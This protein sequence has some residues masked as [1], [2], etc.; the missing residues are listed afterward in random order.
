VSFHLPFLSGSSRVSRVTHARC[1][2]SHATPS[3]HVV[4]GFPEAFVEVRQRLAVEFGQ[5]LRRYTGLNHLVQAANA[6]LENP[7]HVR[8]MVEDY[9]KVGCRV[10]SAAAAALHD[11]TRRTHPSLVAHAHG[12]RQCAPD[13]RHNTRAHMLPIFSS[14]HALCTFTLPCVTSRGCTPCGSHMARCAPALDR[15]T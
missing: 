11:F 13:N 5:R 10:A 3:T 1:L 8:Q 4:T 9:D 2:C 15:W 6:V 14:A 12:M 7:A